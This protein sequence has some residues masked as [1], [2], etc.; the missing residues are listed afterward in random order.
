MRKPALFF[1]PASLLAI[2]LLASA[3]GADWGRA[4][5]EEI[6][7]QTVPAAAAGT[8]QVETINGNVTVRTWDRDEVYVKAT[9]EA[10]GSSS[11]A[12]RELLEETGIEID[13]GDGGVSIRT[14][15]PK[16]S[17]KRRAGGGV[18]VSYELTVP[19][20]ATV[21]ARSTNGNVEVRGLDGP[22]ALTSTNGTIELQDVGGDV[23]ARTTNGDIRARGLGGRL[24]GR[25]TNGTIRAELRA[26]Q[27]DDDMQL[28]TTNG[29]IELDVAAGLA[30]EIDAR[31]SSGRV[32]SELPASYEL[33]KSAKAATYLLGGGGPRVKLRTT[34]GTIRLRQTG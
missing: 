14:R 12:A 9:K 2:L 8:V 6:F 13:A 1:V 18:S 30:A 10:R 7:E 16:S 31:A 24:D 11:E 3:A 15:P 5:E 17:W 20:R 32:V 4:K 22:A 21:E 34:N 23:E 26:A 27:L 33:K 25:T 19:R 28:T 29:S